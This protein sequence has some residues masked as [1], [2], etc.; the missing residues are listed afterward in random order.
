MEALVTKSKREIWID[1][2]KGPFNKDT[3]VEEI[4]SKNCECW[5]LQQES[6]RNSENLKLECTACISKLVLFMSFYQQVIGTNP[7]PK[8]SLEMESFVFPNNTVLNISINGPGPYPY[9]L[10]PALCMVEDESEQAG[11]YK[12]MIGKELNI[13][14]TEMKGLKTV[15]RHGCQYCFEAQSK[16]MFPQ[17]HGSRKTVFYYTE[18]VEAW[19]MKCGDIKGYDDYDTPSKKGTK[20][21]KGTKCGKER[22]K[23]EECKKTFLSYG[24]KEYYMKCKMK[25]RPVYSRNILPRSLTSYLFILPYLNFS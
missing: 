22:H 17:T 7:C 16:E 25:Y 12:Y 14:Y 4:A 1:L 10:R 20:A 13:S 3:D 9:H 23:C 6:A 19:K 5:T 21:Q 24:G 8:G 18:P 11:K 15:L 2:R